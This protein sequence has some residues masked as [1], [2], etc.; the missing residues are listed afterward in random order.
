MRII[1]KREAFSSVIKNEIHKDN[2]AINIE[3]NM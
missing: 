1:N 2:R 3:I